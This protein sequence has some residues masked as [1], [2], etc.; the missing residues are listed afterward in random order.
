MS[1]VQC[2]RTFVMERLTVAAEEI[3]RVFQLKLDGY[4][5]ELDYQRRLVESVWRPQ[6]KLHRTELSQQQPLWKEEEDNYQHQD[7]SCS[8]DQE[9]SKPPQINEEQKD[10]CCYQDGEPLTV[11]QE[12]DTLMVTIHEQGDDSELGLNPDQSQEKPEVNTTVQS[13]VLPDP[14]C[15]LQLLSYSPHISE[16]KDEENSTSEDSRWTTAE[17]PKQTMKQN[18]PKCQTGN[19]NSPA[20]SAVDCDT[21]TGAKTSA[22]NTG[23]QQGKIKTDLKRHSTIQYQHLGSA[24]GK[25]FREGCFSSADKIKDT[26]TKFF[27][28]ET[29]GKNFKLSKSLKQH[30]KVHTDERP[31]ACKTCGK[32]FKANTTLIIHMRVHTGERPYACNICGKTFKQHS[33]L[34]LHKRIHT[35]E[36]PHVCKTCGKTFIQND[37]LNNHLR[38]HTGE[39]PFVCKTCGKAFKQNY[40]LKIHLRDHTGERPFVCKTCGKT[41][42]RNDELKF[43]LRD[44][45]GERPFV[46]KTCGKTFKRHS[47]L[48]TH[49]RVHTG[50][51]PFVCKACGKTFAQNSA[52]HA[53]TRR[54]TSERPF[55]CKTCGK[56]FKQ[57]YSLTVHMRIHKGE[58][59]CV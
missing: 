20:E 38:V 46:C 24:C 48:K 4:E 21:D 3:F 35:G 31:Y 29:C 42:K 27:I 44:H 11:K 17:E 47:E 33:S 41:F 52:L 12:M 59:I 22:S 5:E 10:S 1:S 57:N 30:L 53:H 26:A 43:H 18:H 14:A 2:L 6:L 23:E 9:D 49:L 36:R 32:T 16:S 51:R 15:D 45:T 8:L 7:R 25:D 56:T 50:E 13:P 28:C 39:R 37:K 40:D 54:H 55:L 34:Y 58:T 19:V